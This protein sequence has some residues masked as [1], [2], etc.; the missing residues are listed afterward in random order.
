MKK[1]HFCSI[2]VCAF[3]L[4]LSSFSQTRKELEKKR[5]ELKK[6]IE[7]VNSLLFK[8]K[9]QKSNALD[10]LKDLNQ[11]I[12]IR[13]RLIETIELEAKELDK[14]IK[15]NKKQLDNYNKE[16]KTLKESYSDMVVKT[17]K[18]KSLQSKTMFLLS[19]ESF[20]QAYKRVKYMQQYN[21]FRKQQGEEIIV[22]T[23]EVEKLNDSLLDRKKIK[24]RLI[25][26]EK[27]NKEEI[28]SDKKEQ[29]KLISTI[30]NQESKYKKTL[31][32][33]QKEEKKVAAK[34]DKLI[35]EAIAK[36]NKEKGAKKSAEFSLNAEEKVL[37]ANFEQNK[38]NL[39]WPVK[40]IITRK[41]GVQPHPTFPG[42]NINSTGLHIAAQ[43]NSDARSIF[44]GKVLIIQKHSDGKRSVYVQHGNYISVYNSLENVYVKKGDAIKTGEKLGRIFTDKVTGKTKL[45]FV[46]YKNTTRLNPSDW[47]Q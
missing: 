35:R 9:K 6:E 4:S 32:D 46:L 39:P 2:I 27:S 12:S 29:E 36:S 1:F 11:K 41:F 22:K 19:S 30:K 10:D 38:G 17:H 18:S 34:I 47:I 14:E 26:E 33:K 21:D 42:I 28:E 23:K 25:S 13:E 8:T 31:I 16:L 45:S 40:G 37:L 3:L 20:Y 24:I 15:K 44:N 7:Q 43:E 5:S